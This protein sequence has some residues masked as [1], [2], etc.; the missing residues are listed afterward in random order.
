MA[1]A[2]AGGG[3]RIMC[4]KSIVRNAYVCQVLI[5]TLPLAHQRIFN[6]LLL[7]FDLILV[8]VFVKTTSRSLRYCKILFKNSY[9]VSKK[10]IKKIKIKRQKRR[11]SRRQ[12]KLLMLGKCYNL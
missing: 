4:K 7:G 2:I 8:V 1:G 9:N 5:N 10:L 12:G 6:V 11:E 3:A